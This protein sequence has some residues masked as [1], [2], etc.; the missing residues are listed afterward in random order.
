MVGRL[1]PRFD[2]LNARLVVCIVK[3]FEGFDS[4]YY[5][6]VVRRWHS[7]I[8]IIVINLS[9]LVVCI[10]QLCLGVLACRD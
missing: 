6:L 1:Y 8:A 7:G 4:V 2:F 5:A 3:I 9:S 10:V